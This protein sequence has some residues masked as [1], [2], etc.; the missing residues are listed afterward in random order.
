MKGISATA[1]LALG[2]AVVIAV[3]VYVAVVDLGMNAGKIHSGVTLGTISVGGMTQS[4]AA[5]HLE[6][7]GRQ[8]RDEPV[9]FAV[10][11]LTFEIF[12]A[13]VR[14]QPSSEDMAR[15]AMS[16]GR[17]GGLTHAASAR[18]QA[19]FGGV[20]L[21]WRRPGARSLTMEI[22]ELSDELDGLGYDLDEEG[23]RRAL[24]QA[25]WDWPRQDEYQIPLVED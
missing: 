5:A 11:T 25:I 9:T 23:M 22:E 2:T 13:D 1:K 18:W 21:S 10:G 24:K 16:V 17:G 3:A 20:E 8:M 6:T 19:W 12:P 15:K 14:W 7:V 4:E